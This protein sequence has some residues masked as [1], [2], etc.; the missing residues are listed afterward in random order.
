MKWLLAAACSR[1]VWRIGLWPARKSTNVVGRAE[2]E[3]VQVMKKACSTAIVIFADGGRDGGSGVVISPD[4]YALS[5]FHVVSAAGNAMKCGMADGRLYDAVLVGLD[6]VGDVA[7]VKL[8]GRDDFPCAEHGRQRHGSHRRLGVCRRQPVSA[9]Y[10]FSADGDL[11]HCLRRSPLPVPVGHAAG[12]RRLPADRCLDQS[13][14]FRRSAVQCR[15]P[16]DRHQRPRFVREAR[17]R[18][19]RR[20][21]RHLHQSDQELSGLSEERTD[22][23]PCHARR[24]RGQRR[25]GPRRRL[26]HSRRFGRLPARTALRRRDRHLRRP[27]NPHGQRLQERAGHLSQGLAGAAVVS[28]LRASCTTRSCGWPASTASRS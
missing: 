1:S 22:C 5:N 8:L 18:E 15:G 4:G 16:A 25:A 23:R 12:I 24:P 10:R 20:G 21:L 19:R 7:L 6:P 17:P 2:R 27:A 13:R 14:Q 28:P 26:G 11:R 3:R 9:G